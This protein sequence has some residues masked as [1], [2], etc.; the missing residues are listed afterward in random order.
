MYAF[1]GYGRLHDESSSDPA[2]SLEVG[3]NFFNERRIR[4]APAHTSAGVTGECCIEPRRIA[5][6]LPTRAIA[7]IYRPAQDAVLTSHGIQCH[8]LVH[9]RRRHLFTRP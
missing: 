4:S 2:S 8:G 3:Q 6:E 1:K 7:T 5:P 9:E